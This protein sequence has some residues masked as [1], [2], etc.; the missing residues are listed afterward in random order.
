MTVKTGRMHRIQ[1]AG[2]ASFAL[3]LPGLGAITPAPASASSSHDRDGFFVLSPAASDVGPSIERAPKS[4]HSREATREIPLKSGTSAPGG[5]RP[6]GTADGALQTSAKLAA[7]TIAGGVARDGVGVG[8]TPTYSDCC[9]PPDTNLAVGTTQVVQWVNLDFAAFDK[10]TGALLVGYPKAGNSIWAGFGTSCETNSVGDPIVKFDAQNSRW[11]M[12]QLSGTTA[13]YLQC[14]AVSQTADFTTTP[15]NRYAYN[16]GTSLPDYPKVGIWP[17]GYYFSFNMFQNGNAFT[18]AEACAL[19]GATAR[20]AG[21]ATM[22]CFPFGTSVASLL[23]GDLDGATGAVGTTALP[24]AGSPNYF[25]NFGSNAL[26][27][28]KFHAD[29]ANSANAT[30]TAAPTIAT[31]AFSTACGGGACVPQAGTAQQLETLADRLMYRL[32]YRNFPTYES[33]VVTHSV[34]GSG[35]AAT[36]WYELRKTTGDFGI[37]QQSSYAPDATYRWMG[38]A[39]QDKKGDLALGYSASSGTISP[40]IRY[41]GRLATDKPL[42]ALRVEVTAPLPSTGSNTGPYSRW[43]DYSSLSLDPADDCTFWYTAMY[44]KANGGSFTWSTFIL[45][46]KFIGCS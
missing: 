25:A 7:A 44:Y 10:N 12:T 28:W 16:H 8:I 2:A 43:G 6:R 13:P 32:T 41:A 21:S 4:D 24:P 9:T 15:W 37:Y 39:A 31:A 40:T 29:F 22:Q 34:K 1:L 35:T 3:L 11:I 26:N 20:S 36:R 33:L 46:F 17:D 27:L 19:D 23:P 38:S 14:V 42:G 45:N 18:G 30:L 5:N